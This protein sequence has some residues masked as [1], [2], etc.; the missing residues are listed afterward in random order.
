MLKAYL[1][2]G[3][4]GSSTDN[5]ACV[6]CT[7][8]KENSY[9]QFVRPWNRMLR[10]WGASAFHATDFY[11][12]GGEFE[13]KTA[14]RKRWF[15]RDSREIPKII[16]ENVH[17]ILAVAFRP[18]EYA[19]M[20]SQEW[21]DRFGTDTHA[22]AV[23]LC[24]VFNGLW[25]Q[26]KR[27]TEY[28]AYVRE[29]GDEGEGAVDE[30][31]RKLGTNP[32]YARVIRVTSYKTVDKGNARGTEASDFVAWHWNKYAVETFPA[33]RPPRKDFI[34]LAQLTEAR[35]KVQSA[36]ITGDK[37]RIFF[38]TLEREVRHKLRSSDANEKDK[39]AQ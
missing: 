23:Q 35:G 18:E 27:S 21:K 1:D 5:I 36:F 17:R 32:E 10:R 6:A 15:D 16:G 34:A 37:L 24:L 22:I 26:E 38:D 30:A 14:E 19:A 33:G 29:A 20:A 3:V 11:P 28:F 12:G 9:K 39:T 2:R 4:K 7:V 13:R 8:F 31:V 25:L